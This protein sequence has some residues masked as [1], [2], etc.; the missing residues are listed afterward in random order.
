[1]V[2]KRFG[3]REKEVICDDLA[4]VP[5]KLMGCLVENDPDLAGFK[6]HEEVHNGRRFSRTSKLFNFSL[7]C[8][9]KKIEKEIKIRIDLDSKKA[10]KAKNNGEE[11]TLTEEELQ[12]EHNRE[13]EAYHEIPLSTFEDSLR[14]QAILDAL[15][16]SSDGSNS[17]C[18]GWVSVE[19]DEY[20]E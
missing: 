7:L 8:F 19:L 5:K 10:K 2:T 4:E 16:R 18:S 11:V 9:A 14:S 17:G 13:V 6:D 15:R 12:E 3:C 1:M 20:Y